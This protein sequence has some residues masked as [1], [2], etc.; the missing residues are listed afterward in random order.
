MKF[1]EQLIIIIFIIGFG[2]VFDIL[3]PTVSLLLLLVPFLLSLTKN[4]KMS[5]SPKYFPI[6]FIFIL[7]VIISS[8]ITET[9]ILLYGSFLV[10][11]FLILFVLAIY[12]YDYGKIAENIEK[13]L[14]AVAWLALA[15]F[16]LANLL[17]SIFTPATN[18]VYRVNTIFYLFNYLEPTY[19]WGLT[20]YRNQ[21]IFWEPGVLAIMMNFLILIKVIEKGEKLT[22]AILPII[23]VLTT[24]STAGYLGMS[25][26]L[27]YWIYKKNKQ[28]NKHFYAFFVGALVLLIFVP[29]VIQEV[30]YKMTIGIGS[31]SARQYDLLVG[32]EMI[33]DN[34]FFGIGLDK[35]KYLREL[36]KYTIDIYNYDDSFARNNSNIFISLFARLGI[37]MGLLFMIGIYKQN[38]FQHRTCFFLVACVGMMSEPV[39]FV[40]FY[41]LLI[42]SSVKAPLRRQSVQRITGHPS[43]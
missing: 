42:L 7:C 17:P 22:K 16:F 40:N 26:V 25:I 37:P 14:V 39:L 15:N 32:Y 5:I 29:I 35:E 10:R 4:E 18:G 43:V 31:A 11:P 20:I 12:N 9:S 1:V 19:R 8:F 38:I 24:L 3:F 27:I 28:T 41:F 23:V 30:E 34:P 13:V 2:S 6:V 21:G 36:S 33:K